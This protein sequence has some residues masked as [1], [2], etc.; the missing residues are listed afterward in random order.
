MIFQKVNIR[1]SELGKQYCGSVNIY[2]GNISPDCRR[3]RNKSFVKENSSPVQQKH[4][5]QA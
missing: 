1:Y 5:K 2:L 3:E 4:H